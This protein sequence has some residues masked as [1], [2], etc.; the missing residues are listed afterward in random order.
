MPWHIKFFLGVFGRLNG[1]LKLKTYQIQSQR[2]VFKMHD[3]IQKNSMQ[4]GTRGRV[5][6]IAGYLMVDLVSA[7]CW[8]I[9][10]QYQRDIII[11]C[12]ISRCVSTFQHHTQLH[13]K[14]P[15]FRMNFKLSI[16]KKFTK[17]IE[18]FSQVLVSI[19]FLATYLCKHFYYDYKNKINVIQQE[20][21]PMD[22]EKGFTSWQT[23]RV[24]RPWAR[25][26]E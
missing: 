24:W 9:R 16:S 21:T 26:K 5:I 12:S 15:I 17:V 10:A 4:A 13:G 20:P 19:A 11:A 7:M 3:C 6:V 14:A 18:Y 2:N 25:W 1:D 22:G 8:S 23:Q